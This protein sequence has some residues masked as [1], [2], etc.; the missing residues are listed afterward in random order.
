MKT[1]AGGCGQGL[2]IQVLGLLRLMAYNLVSHL[3]SRYLRQR[4][5]RASAKRRWQEWCDLMLLVIAGTDGENR[6]LPGLTGN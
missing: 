2:G 5:E 3:R 1:P 6:V 4:D